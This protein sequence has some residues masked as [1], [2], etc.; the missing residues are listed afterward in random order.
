MEIP[1]DLTYLLRNLYGIKKQQLE[2]HIEQLTD[3][4]LGMKYYKT[5][6]FH[7]LI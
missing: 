2:T 7:L 1:D 6:Y 5:V 4:K 3:S